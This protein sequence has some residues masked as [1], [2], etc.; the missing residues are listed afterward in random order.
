MLPLFLPPDYLNNLSPDSAEYD[1]TQG[2]SSE[3]QRRG[4]DP[5]SSSLPYPGSAP[6]PRLDT[7]PPHRWVCSACDVRHSP[8]VLR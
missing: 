2:K 8:S 6:V 3:N 4:C 7:P 5:V 1:S